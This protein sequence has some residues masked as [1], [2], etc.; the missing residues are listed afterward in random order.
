[1]RKIIKVSVFHFLV[2]LIYLFIDSDL[3]SD[4]ILIAIYNLYCGLTADNDISGFT[5]ITC[6]TLSISLICT[7][8]KEIGIYYDMYKY[9]WCRCRSAVFFIEKCMLKIIILCISGS[10]FIFIICNII[11]CIANTNLYFIVTMKIILLI[12]LS[13]VQYSLLIS[14][15]YCLKFG[16]NHILLLMSV[17]VILSPVINVSNNFVL[18]LLVLFPD[19]N[20]IGF[21]LISGKIILILFL[22]IVWWINQKR[23]EEIDAKNNK[24]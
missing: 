2:F 13:F 18:K 7:L 11:S 24:V 8:Q 10:F 23:Y 21:N 16:Y 22:M 1:M 3:H 20:A 9:I 5:I 6:V 12:F 4:D 14:N 17:L 15:L 19:V